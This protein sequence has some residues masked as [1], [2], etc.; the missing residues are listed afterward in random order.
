MIAVTRHTL[1]L[2]ASILAD[3]IVV[4]GRAT[5]VRLS[6]VRTGFEFGIAGFGV[7]P[8]GGCAGGAPFSAD[9]LSA[10]CWA[11]LCVTTSAISRTAANKRLIGRRTLSMDV[12]TSS[13]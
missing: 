7:L 1:G 12:I 13:E 2:F 6:Q 5:I 4:F 10:P 9:P 11:S 8:N 3:S